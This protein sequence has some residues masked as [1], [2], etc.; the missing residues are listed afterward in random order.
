M[1]RLL[2]LLALI[3]GGCTQVSFSVFYTPP[4][5]FGFT[6]SPATTQGAK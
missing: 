4:M 1:R 5:T 6:L 3:L 2:P